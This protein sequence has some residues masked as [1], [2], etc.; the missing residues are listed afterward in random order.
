MSE[1]VAERRGPVVIGTMVAALLSVAG[2]LGLVLG[3]VIL[4]N[5][6]DDPTPMAQLG[7]VTFPITPITMAVYG[8]V[9]VGVMAGGGLLLVRAVSRRYADGEY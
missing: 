8:V 5:Q 6:I 7:P 2:L 3:A 9:M 4:P 1:E